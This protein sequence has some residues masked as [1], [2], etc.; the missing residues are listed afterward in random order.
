[1]SKVEKG[2]EILELL[3]G[4]DTSARFARFLESSQ[5]GFGDYLFYSCGEFYGDQTLALKTKQLIV[6]AT[7]ITQKDTAPQLRNHLLGCK[8]AGLTR[9][10][11]VAAILRLTL[12]IG[13]PVVVNAL[14]ILDDVF[15]ANQYAAAGSSPARR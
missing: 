2:R 1:M 12:Y 6:I 7:L 10:Q 11:V 9:Q 5:Q 13:F 15:I 3:W 8:N 4:S 14:E